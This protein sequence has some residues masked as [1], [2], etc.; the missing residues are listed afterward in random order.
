MMNGFIPTTRTD[1]PAAK[2]AAILVWTDSLSMNVTT[3]YSGMSFVT[4][5]QKTRDEVCLIGSG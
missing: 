1:S 5:G 4:G 3:A 2:R